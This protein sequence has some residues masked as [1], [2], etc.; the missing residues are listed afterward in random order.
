MGFWA[1]ILILCL[2]A[3]GFFLFLDK[4]KRYVFGYISILLA[5]AA[6]VIIKTF[7]LMSIEIKV[8]LFC[9][10]VITVVVSLI[11]FNKKTTDEERKEIANRL[12][13]APQ[14]ALATIECVK[15][16]LLY[17]GSEAEIIKSKADR[18]EESCEFG[19]ECLC[20]TK[21]NKWF[22]LTF[23]FDYRFNDI[24]GT[25]VHPIKVDDAKM[26]LSKDVNEYQ[27][28]FGEVVTA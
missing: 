27:K 16:D 23:Q 13:K 6:G 14:D 9:I 8:A 25:N 22:I 18:I 21:A 17:L 2:M 5:L 24:L 1:V 20:K 11:I 19:F 7:E 4:K 15:D 26:Y 3:G 10:A 28:H 12:E